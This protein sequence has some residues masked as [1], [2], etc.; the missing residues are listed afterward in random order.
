M[1][2]NCGAFVLKFDVSIHTPTQG[3]TGVRIIEEAYQPVSI[4]TPTQG[5]TLPYAAIH[6]DGGV[7]I[8]TPTQGVTA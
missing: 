7:S 1:T 6:N 4:H 8:H 3:V 2:Y 5:V